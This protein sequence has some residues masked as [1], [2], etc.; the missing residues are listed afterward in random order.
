MM[1]AQSVAITGGNGIV[2]Q[3]L[4]E[5]FNEHGHETINISRGKS[6]EEISDKFRSTD[7]LDAGEVYGSLA[8]SG[9]DAV[10]HMGTIRWPIEHPWHVTYQSQ[11]MTSYNILEAATNL[12]IDDVVL[13]SSINVMGSVYQDAPIE[14]EYLPVDEAHPITPRDPYA[15]GKHSVEVTADGFARLPD[16]PE[17]IASLRYPWVASE[18]DIQETFVE[19]DR[20]LDGLRDAWHHTTRDVLFSYIHD[21]DA[22]S[23]AR[24][25]IEADFTGHERFWAVAADTSANVKNERL[26][27]EYYPAVEV[28]GD[29][30]PFES[31][32]SIEKA[33]N[34]LDWEPKHSWR[35]LST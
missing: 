27:A 6:N 12:G 4:L 26:I 22:A 34:I 5:H 30:D 19:N 29:L 13:P 28:P 20:T 8:A 11:V 32:I 23:I 1:S 24:R 17:S 14:V 3:A 33:R 9:A 35:D 16:G 7:L 31:L 21:E 25:A 10:I 15:L 2:G 18:M